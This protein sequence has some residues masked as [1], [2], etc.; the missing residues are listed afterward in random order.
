VSAALFETRERDG[1]LW[2]LEVKPY[3]G[4]MRAYWWKW[5]RDD[6]GTLHSLKKGGAI[7]PPEQLLDLLAA[8]EA[9]RDDNALSGPESG[10]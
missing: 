7:F 2:R 6:N 10:S 8:L 9:W 3:K 5:W 1:C 4:H